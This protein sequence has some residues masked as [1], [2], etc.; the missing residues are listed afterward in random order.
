MIITNKTYYINFIINDNTNICPTDLKKIFQE[1]S[2]IGSYKMFK[3]NPNEILN[4]ECN[5]NEPWGIIL[6]TTKPI[7]KI[8]DILRHS[9]GDYKI[10]KLSYSS[11]N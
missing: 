2:R 10:F 4:Y 3:H 8:D 1:F 11:F 9:V 5:N 6:S 7:E